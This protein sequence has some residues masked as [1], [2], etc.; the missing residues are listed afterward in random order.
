MNTPTKKY[1]TI[2]L[3][4]VNSRVKTLPEQFYGIT[5]ILKTPSLLVTL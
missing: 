3:L 1:L 4:K 5:R 2:K